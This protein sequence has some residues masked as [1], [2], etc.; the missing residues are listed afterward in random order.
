[1]GNKHF[2]PSQLRQSAQTA[3][4]TATQT[5]NTDHSQENLKPYRSSGFQES[6]ESDPGLPGNLAFITAR[7]AV[8]WNG[9]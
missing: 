9:V 6:D 1:M 2:T 8:E 5:S 4:A 7:T 3:V